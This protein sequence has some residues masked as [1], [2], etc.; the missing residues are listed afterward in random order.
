[1]QGGLRI[2]HPVANDD[3]LRLLSLHLID[4]VHEG[5]GMLGPQAL[6]RLLNCVDLRVVGTHDTQ[7]LTPELAVSRFSGAPGDCVGCHCRSAWRRPRQGPHHRESHGSPPACGSVHL[8]HGRPEGS[9][10]RPPTGATPPIRSGEAL[11]R[12]ASER[13]IHGIKT[14]ANSSWRSALAWWPAACTQH[15]SARGLT[16]PPQYHPGPRAA[17]ANATKTASAQPQHRSSPLV[18]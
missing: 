11:S 8:P 9:G 16:T 1:L 10:A 18:R 17:V 5:G 13:L 4:R 3:D 6:Q 2:A 14:A 12:A 7:P 15:L